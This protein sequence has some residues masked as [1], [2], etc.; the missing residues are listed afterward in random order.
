MENIYTVASSSASTTYGNI[1]T[2]IREYLKKEFPIGYFKDIQLSSEIAY[3]NVQRRLG[4]NSIIELSKLEKPYLTISPRI[5]VPSNGEYLYNI[6]LTKNY[7]NMEYGVSRNTL[8]HFLTNKEDGYLLAYKL[9]RDKIQFEITI[10]ISTLIQQ[11]DLYKYLVNHLTW[12]RPYVVKTSLESM[13]PRNI[14]KQ[15]GILSNIDIDST[16]SNQI[17]N[18]LQLMNRY[19]RYPVT[20]KMRNGTSLNEFFLYYTA[21]LLIEFDE[22][23]LDD[24]TKKNFAD[25]FYQ[26]HFN[27]SVE[28][29]LPGYFALIGLQPKPRSLNMSIRVKEPD[30]DHD[31]IP[32]FTVDNFFNRYPAVR[33]GFMFYRASRFQVCDGTKLYDYTDIRELFEDWRLEV[34]YRYNRMHVPMETLINLILLK[35]GKELKLGNWD[36]TWHDMIL[37][38]K[39]PDERATYQL[40]VYVNNNLFVEEKKEEAELSKKDK[41]NL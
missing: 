1:M 21:E 41:P 27:C 23:T 5:E 25:D 40:I 14:I 9:N 24:A 17:P 16:K 13:I 29:N 15:I 32:L 38:I 6:P 19:S 31:L 4:R 11:L 22:L 2:F 36:I 26:I 8:F 10:T 39:D 28:F 35:D 12:E 37:R 3:V 7:N 30:G 33:N 20:Y 18:I 34:I